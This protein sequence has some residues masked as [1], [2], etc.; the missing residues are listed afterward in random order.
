MAY[1][2]LDPFL[3]FHRTEPD[4]AQSDERGETA[5]LAHRQ[6]VIQDWLAGDLPEEAVLETLLDQGISPDEYCSAVAANIEFVMGQPY[7]TNESG[8]LLPTYLGV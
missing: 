5:A 8:I 4:M 7:V 6:Q 1:D 2:A 3:T